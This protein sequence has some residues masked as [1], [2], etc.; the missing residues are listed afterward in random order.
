VLWFYD[1]G[2][3][4]HKLVVDPDGKIVF[5]RHG[6]NRFEPLTEAEREALWGKESGK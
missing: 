1:V 5:D 4:T 6:R 3:E 2:S